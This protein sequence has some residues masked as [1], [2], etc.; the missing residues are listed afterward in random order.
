MNYITFFQKVNKMCG[1]KKKTAQVFLTWWL[2]C[3]FVLLKSFQ[4]CID[5][6]TIL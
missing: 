5:E 2:I 1:N 3:V 6:H 4:N